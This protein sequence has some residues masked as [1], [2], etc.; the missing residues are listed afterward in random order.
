MIYG[1][2]V[3][4]RFLGKVKKKMD[5]FIWFGHLK[6]TVLIFCFFFCFVVPEFQPP[7]QRVELT[8]ESERD[9]YILSPPTTFI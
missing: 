2:L 1:E 8:L 9:L 3:E 5:T 7:N 6:T 4:V